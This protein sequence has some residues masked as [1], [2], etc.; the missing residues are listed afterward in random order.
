MQWMQHESMRIEGKTME[1]L[2]III[3][4]SYELSAI[5]GR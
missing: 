2:L 4:P 1:R 3:A 5:C